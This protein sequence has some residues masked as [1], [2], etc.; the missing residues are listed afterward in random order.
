MKGLPTQ[1]YWETWASCWSCR[2]L[3]SW[4]ER[5]HQT[6]RPAFFFA[7]RVKVVT[8]SKVA[9]Y[10]GKQKAPFE[11]ICP[12]PYHSGSGNSP[13]VLHESAFTLF[14]SKFSVFS[15]SHHD[16]VTLSINMKQGAS[17]WSLIDCNETV[18]HETSTSNTHSWEFAIT[19]RSRNLYLGIPFTATCHH[20]L[21]TIASLA[22][23]HLS[24]SLICANNGC[25]H[26]WP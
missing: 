11:T 5:R 6:K 4:I 26:K 18:K 8:L 7:L 12:L 19:L 2:F 9:N 24:S 14:M 15:M 22:E 16:D 10:I 25:L 13:S 1:G 20:A 21:G 23:R 3:S 17:C